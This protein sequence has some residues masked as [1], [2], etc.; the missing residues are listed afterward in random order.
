M[1]RG[2]GCCAVDIYCTAAL[3]SLSDS[4]SYI[5]FLFSEWCIN[6][7]N[8]RLISYVVQL[9]CRTKFIVF[10]QKIMECIWFGAAVARR[11]KYTLI[12]DYIPRLEVFS[13]DVRI[14][15]VLESLLVCFR[16]S[17]NLKLSPISNDSLNSFKTF[18]K[19]TSA[20]IFKSWQCLPYRAK[21]TN[22]DTL[23]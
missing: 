4:V 20:Y 12:C 6:I 19:F 21:V 2:S 22:F 1:K 15:L 10:R 5:I 3:T 23:R 17:H 14:M 18:W 16:S 9:P 8:V 7:N 11:M 13:Q